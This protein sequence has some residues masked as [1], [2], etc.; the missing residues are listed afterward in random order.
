M[1]KIDEQFFHDIR[2]FISGTINPVI[3]FFFIRLISMSSRKSMGKK[4]LHFDCNI[5]YFR[6]WKW[7]KPFTNFDMVFDFLIQH[8]A[9]YGFELVKLILFVTLI[10]L[11][12]PTNMLSVVLFSNL[13]ESTHTVSFLFEIIASSWPNAKLI[14]PY[15]CIDFNFIES[16]DLYLFKFITHDA[17]Q[18]HQCN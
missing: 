3:F 10:R 17:N 6:F 13:F 18:K 12:I 9:F 4:C 1:L 7:L 11:W 16:R 2:T 15:K 5:N 14:Q 8:K